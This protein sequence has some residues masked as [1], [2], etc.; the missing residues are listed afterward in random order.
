M[1]N[2]YMSDRTTL[3]VQSP[4]GWVALPAGY[5]HG[6][7]EITALPIM[8]TDGYAARVDWLTAQDWCRSFDWDLSTVEE[9][10]TLAR[11]AHHVDPYTLPT[12]AQLVAAVP[13]PWQDKNGRDTPAMRRFRSANI[14]SEAWCRKHDLE[15]WR[16]LSESG[17]DGVSPVFNF[18]KHWARNGFIYGWKMHGGGMIQDASLA[19]RGETRQAAYSDYATTFHAVR[20]Q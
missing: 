18:G 14:R 15:V 11:I 10:A 19:H 16:R 9:L 13:K 5:G 4:P 8:S 12:V 2:P 17:W 1:R 20:Y 3:C 7:C 6:K